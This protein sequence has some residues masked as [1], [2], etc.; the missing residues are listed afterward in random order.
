MAKGIY[1]NETTFK[2]LDQISLEQEIATR[3]VATG[4]FTGWFNLLPDPDPI[5]RKLGE[6][7]QVY[8]DLMS[9]DQVGSTCIRL[10]NEVKSMEWR[11][12]P[13][14]D[15]QENDAEMI[16]CNKVLSS[17]QDNGFEIEDIISQSITPHFWG[18]APFE[19]N[20]DQ[21]KKPWLPNKLQLKPVEW[22][23]FD[24][25]NNLLLKTMLQPMG[26]PITGP[27]ADPNF[28]YMFFN[29][30]NEPT[31]ENPYG[32]K[33]LSRCFWAVTFKRGGLKFL[34]WFIERYGMPTVEM[35]HPPG[36]GDEA[37]EKLVQA[38]ALM[39][40]DS[41]IAIPDGNSITIHRG[42]EKQSGELYKMYVDMCDAMVDKA[43]L[44]TTLATSQQSKGGYSSAAAGDE[45]VQRLGK[46]LKKYPQLLL[47]NIFKAAVNLNIGSTR[48]PKFDTFD[49]E[50]PN[51]EFAEV[52]KS[53]S[54][55][56]QASGQQIKRTKKFYQNRFN[57]KP[58]EFEIVDAVVP[59]KTP[60]IPQFSETDK[61]LLQNDGVPAVNVPDKITQLMMETVLQPVIQHIEKNADRK[62]MLDELAKIY[63]TMKSTDRENILTNLIFIYSIQGQL[64]AQQENK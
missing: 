16:L 18:M 30:R 21:S 5:L 6:S 19:C 13:A 47:S 49:E 32:D 61:T 8:K 38:A 45:V 22:F 41:V 34:A 31:F 17:L 51:K 29:L 56:A 58:D 14:K 4:N 44:L 7:A 27:N 12:K 9:D 50:Q 39:I 15:M 53:I 57:Y 43:I 10:K 48:Y 63:P 24:S 54:E 33:A 46:Q 1:V 37:I 28:K 20:W 36:I 64:D 2:T 35:K 55:G 3:A 23:N 25:E 52:D 42:G 40:Q 62:T 59:N 60:I 26:I 11:I